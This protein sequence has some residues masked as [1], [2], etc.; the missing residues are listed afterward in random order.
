MVDLGDLD[1]LAPICGELCANYS[2]ADLDGFAS[3]SVQRLRESYRPAEHQASFEIFFVLIAHSR[4]SQAISESL[5]G[6]GILGNIMTI[7]RQDMERSVQTQNSTSVGDLFA[8]YGNLLFK[9]PRHA[10]HY[11]HEGFADSS[12]K[13]EH[14]RRHDQPFCCTKDGCSRIQT[15]FC[16]DAELQRHIKKRHSLP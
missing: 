10:C 6:L 2:P 8:L 5:T 12:S 7:V 1:K 13:Q 3:D 16:S 9:Y 14:L 11:F 15:G 4:D